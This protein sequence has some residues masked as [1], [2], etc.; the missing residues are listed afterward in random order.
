MG[1]STLI[2]ALGGAG[3]TTARHAHGHQARTK[4]LAIT[5]RTAGSTQTI[6]AYGYGKPTK[7]Q[8]DMAIEAGNAD[9]KRKGVKSRSQRREQTPLSLPAHRLSI[10]DMPGY[11][12]GS[13]P[14][15]G[16]HI[17]KYLENRKMLKGAVFLVDAEAGLKDADRAAL[18]ILKKHNIR[19]LL[20]VTKAEKI[21]SEDEKDGGSRLGDLCM[22]LWQELRSIEAGSQTWVE[23]ADKGWEKEIWVTSA[24]DAET[25]GQAVGV[26]GARWAVY[27]M[28]GVADP[29]SAAAPAGPAKRAP[30]VIKSF[31]DI[32]RL[33]ATNRKQ[34]QKTRLKATF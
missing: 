8:L 23:G 18:E 10:V 13:R 11:G 29:D 34:A 19:T 21:T 28:A 15:W 32:E 30:P 2:N 4:G 24:G 25:N 22:N 31:E 14:E 6:N 26:A 7:A 5:S 9:R 27:R 16:V 1:K 20:T 12:Q 17:E 3:P 33:M